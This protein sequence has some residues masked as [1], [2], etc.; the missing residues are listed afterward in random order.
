MAFTKVAT[1]GEVAPRKAKQ[2]SVNGRKGGVYNVNGTY[3]AL[4]DV[5]SRR[6]TPSARA[7]VKGQLWRAPGTGPGSMGRPA[8][9][10]VRRPRGA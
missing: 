6:G 5:C 10:G 1:L 9:R 2:V 3:Y 7:S 4:D 8:R